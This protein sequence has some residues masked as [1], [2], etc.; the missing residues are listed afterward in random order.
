MASTD[1]TR[2]TQLRNLRKAG[3]A[4]RSKLAARPVTSEDVEKAL[5]LISHHGFKSRVEHDEKGGGFT[6]KI[7]LSP[8]IAMTM[9][10]AYIE[11]HLG[12]Q[13]GN[14]A[15]FGVHTGTSEIYI[16]VPGSRRANQ[17]RLAELRS[18]SAGG[19]S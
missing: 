4:Q 9:A 17:L 18:M 13:F 10:G 16:D 1:Q 14:S 12:E 19:K 5:R 6:T 7:R 11:N 2:L 8:K 3:L 15:I